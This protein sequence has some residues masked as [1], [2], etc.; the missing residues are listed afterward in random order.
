MFR[1]REEEVLRALCRL[2]R[3]FLKIHDATATKINEIATVT[4]TVR[5]SDGDTVFPVRL[6]GT[7]LMVYSSADEFMF[8]EKESGEIKKGFRYNFSDCVWLHESLKQ[9]LVLDALA[10]I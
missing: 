10:D 2:A 7:E 4:L 8:S 5:Y 9:C 6:S 3:K 1:G